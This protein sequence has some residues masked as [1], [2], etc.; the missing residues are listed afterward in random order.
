MI[1]RRGAALW[2]VINYKVSR[3]RDRKIEHVSEFAGNVLEAM[4]PV[5]DRE[6]MIDDGKRIEVDDVVLTEWDS[7]FFRIEIS[8]AQEAGPLGDGFCVHRCRRASR[9]VGNVPD[10]DIKPVNPDGARLCLS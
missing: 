3:Q 8:G 7:L 6:V 5:N 1:G 2:S 4:F 9:T 10:K